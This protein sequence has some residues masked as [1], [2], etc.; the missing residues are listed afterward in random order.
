[1]AKAGLYSPEFQITTETSVVGSLNFFSSF[2]NNEGY[3]NG[4]S[5]LALNLTPLQTLA[6]T[7]AA[8]VDRLD[9]LLFAYQMTAT[10]R[11]R[12]LQMVGALPGTS[13]SQR[14]DRVKAA[15]IVTAMSPDFVIQK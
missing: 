2:F 4:A 8:L 10:T 12:L 5:R 7:P 9:A 14:K 13:A 1:V 6:A 15:L 3:G 11:T